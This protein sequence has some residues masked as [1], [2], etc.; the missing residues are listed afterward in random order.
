MTGGYQPGPFRTAAARDTIVGA[1]LQSLNEARGTAYDPEPGTVVWVENMALA[2]TL[3]DAWET[4][5]RFALQF[6]PQRMTSYLERWEKILDIV[7]TPSDSAQA[8]R[9]TVA[10]KFRL[11]NV[12]PLV[13]TTQDFLGQI[14]GNVFLNTIHTPSALAKG[15]FPGGIEI[16]GGV[17]LEDGVWH[18]TVSNLAVRL[19]Q[20]LFMTDDEFYDTANKFKPFFNDFLPSWVTFAWGRF[21]LQVG[22]ITIAAGDLVVDGVG[23]AFQ[24]SGGGALAS[25]DTIEVYDD[26]RTLHSLVVDTISSDTVM[27]LLAPALTDITAKPW[28]RMGFFLDQQNLDNSFFNS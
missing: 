23:T 16:P 18:S 5:R 1:I 9:A 20:P 19:T 15:R 25:G 13:Q 11:F 22:T 14:L 2:R 17:T 7:P 21:A 27:T 24:T 12:A 26:E 3:A 8:R 6:D 10:A 4:S 28:R